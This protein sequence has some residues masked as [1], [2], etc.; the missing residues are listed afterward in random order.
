MGELPAFG[1]SLVIAIWKTQLSTT[2]TN[3]AKE[4]AGNFKGGEKKQAKNPAA[5]IQEP[6]ITHL[7]Y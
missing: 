4:S 7:L 1:F 2:S 3:V 5:S 6:P